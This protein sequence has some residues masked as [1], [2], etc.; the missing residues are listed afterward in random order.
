[1]D[2]C[3]LGF[4]CG[5][6]SSADAYH[7]VAPSVD[8]S[9]A[10]SCMRGALAD[11]GITATD[12]TH[13]NAHATSTMAGDLSEAK[14]LTAL[15]G[16]HRRPVTSNKGTTGHMIGGSGAVEA[17]VTLRSLAARMVPPV[18]GLRQLDPCIDLDVVRD[19]PRAIAAGFAL[20]NSFG[21]GGMNTALVLRHAGE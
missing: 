6:A 20:S 5:H 10:L 18:A 14:A 17:I 3:V 12:L 1:M 4:V 2:S 19:E 9:G 16:D 11:A 21:F 7:L 8:G 15:L 13:V